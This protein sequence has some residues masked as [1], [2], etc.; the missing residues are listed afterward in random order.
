MKRKPTEPWAVYCRSDACRRRI[1]LATEV[2][3]VIPSGNV[4]ITMIECTCGT[5]GN[6]Y[7]YVDSPLPTG[8]MLI[9]RGTANAK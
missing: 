1:N 2:V 3:R 6:V 4:N 7:T 8:E 9:A 5:W